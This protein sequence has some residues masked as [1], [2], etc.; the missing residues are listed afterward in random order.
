MP[1][2][3][4][5]LLRISKKTPRFSSNVSLEAGKIAA[6][7]PDHILTAIKFTNRILSN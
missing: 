6:L 2:R 3:R 4:E 1:C 5:R 7:S